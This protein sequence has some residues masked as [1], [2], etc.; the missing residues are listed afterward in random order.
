M[1]AELLHPRFRDGQALRL[2]P[3]EPQVLQEDFCRL[4]DGPVVQVPIVVKVVVGFL[5]LALSP[6]APA[7][8]A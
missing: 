7:L 4:A 3:H 1:A 8:T 5:R 6:W 2:A